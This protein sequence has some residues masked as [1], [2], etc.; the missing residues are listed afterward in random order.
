MSGSSSIFVTDL[1]S[2]REDELD[3]TFIRAGGAGG[4]NVNKVSSAVQLRF[5]VQQSPS[6]PHRV[7]LR[8]EEFAGT[9]ESSPRMSVIVLT[10]NRFHTPGRQPQGRRRAARRAGPEGGV[11]ASKRRVKTRPDST[12][13][14]AA[15]RRQG[16]ALRRESRC[17]GRRRGRRGLSAPNADSA[18]PLRDVEHELSQPMRSKFWVSQRSAVS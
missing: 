10:A 2:I 1:I 12:G 9:R 3:E 13:Q 18:E 16:A 8:L 5:D 11:P 4:Q 15:P 7:K 17:A 14:G 6:L